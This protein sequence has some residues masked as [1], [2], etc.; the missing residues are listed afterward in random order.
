MLSQ[1]VRTIGRI[2]TKGFTFS[3]LQSGWMTISISG[4]SQW[5]NQ[6]NGLTISETSRWIHDCNSHTYDVHTVRQWGSGVININNKK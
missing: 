4:Y 1:Y 2:N 5:D 3:G 6:A